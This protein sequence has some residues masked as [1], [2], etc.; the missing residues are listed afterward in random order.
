M[1]D[2]TPAVEVKGEVTVAGHTHNKD[3]G[4]HILLVACRVQGLEEAAAMESVDLIT[5]K[6][7]LMV[8]DQVLVEGQT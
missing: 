5:L 7:V 8:V 1:V 2:T 6:Q 3:V 4:L